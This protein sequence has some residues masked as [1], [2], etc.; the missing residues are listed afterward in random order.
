MMATMVA[1]LGM[2]TLPAT[3]TGA[4]RSSQMT[5]EGACE[6]V[7]G[8]VVMASDGGALL[9]CQRE[10]QTV[11]DIHGPA[12]M[13]TAVAPGGLAQIVEQAHD[14]NAISG[15]T[16]CVREHMLI[17]LKGVLGKTSVLLVVA[18][19]A[20]LEVARGQEVVDNGFDAG[21]LGCAEDLT[22]PVFGIRHVRH[23]FGI[24]YSPDP[25]FLHRNHA[26]LRITIWCAT[27]SRE[28]L[29]RATWP[30]HDS[31]YRR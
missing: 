15:V 23:G 13:T 10:S 4:V 29:K 14:G 9:V 6:K 12:A 20:T 30:N 21:A 31:L 3:C 11:K 18:I 27:S 26:K 1:E 5:T 24:L 22:D 2:S 8:L 19:A 28:V 16:A 7:K 25:E 17:H